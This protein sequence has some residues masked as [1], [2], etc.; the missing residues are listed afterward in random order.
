[1]FNTNFFVITLLFVSRYPSQNNIRISEAHI[2]NNDLSR[3]NEMRTSKSEDALRHL[4]QGEMMRYASS[5]NIR[6]N[7]R[8][9]TAQ[10]SRIHEQQRATN[11]DRHLRGA[12]KL[13]EMS[14]EVRRRQNRVQHGQQQ[15]N[16]QLFEVV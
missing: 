10:S 13:A 12:A 4:A 3:H 1:M 9:E 11:D 2:Q 14:E 8:I 6:D 7:G 5:G 16:K 15:V